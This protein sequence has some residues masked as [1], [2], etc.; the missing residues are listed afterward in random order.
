MKETIVVSFSGGKTSGYMCKWLLDNYGHLCNFVFIFANTGLEREETLDFVNKC[1]KEFGLNLAWVESVTNPVH[2]KGVTHRITNFNDAYRMHQYKDPKHPFHAH[3][4]KNGIPN[5]NKPQCS[6]RLKEFAIEHYK[7]VNGLKGA[8]HALG[9]RADEPNRVLSKTKRVF[10]KLIGIDCELWRLKDKDSRKSELNRALSM[11]HSLLERASSK[12]EIESINSKLKSLH[13]HNKYNLCY[14][15]SDWID[16][17]KQDVNTMWEDFKFTLHLEEHEGNCSTC[18]KKSEVK[19]WLLAIVQP[20]L[21]EAFRWWE[22]TYKH[23][24]PNA[25]GQDR[26]F[27]RKNRSAD[28][29]IEESKGYTEEYLRKRIG[30]QDDQ[31]SGCSESCEAYAE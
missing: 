4:A 11:V 2:M 13:N 19:I 9:M 3:I 28:M 10:L 25:N 16:I 23:I 21:F 24:K 8:R 15:F 14:P 22:K 30:Y 18:W 31:D 7:K 27:F 12:L 6:D 29:M 1:D 26:V 17:D 5:A 20:H